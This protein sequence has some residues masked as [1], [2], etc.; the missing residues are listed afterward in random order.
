MAG[1]LF[2]QQIF[3]ESILFFL[4]C[5]VLGTNRKIVA[6]IEKVTKVIFRWYEI[7]IKCTHTYQMVIS[8]MSII[9]FKL[10]LS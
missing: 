6:N 2:T 7:E 10:I 3:T 9:Y 5:T 8:V 1:C 4:A